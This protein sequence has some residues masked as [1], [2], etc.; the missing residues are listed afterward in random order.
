M[1][2]L[3]FSF[4]ICVMST[5]SPPKLMAI[6]EFLK[7]PERKTIERWLIRGELVER[8]MSVRNP[9][10]SSVMMELGIIL[11]PGQSHVEALS[12]PMIL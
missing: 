11:G 7:L 1:L 9:F 6:D 8:K 5:D 3:G 2:S 12:F 10:H 4:G